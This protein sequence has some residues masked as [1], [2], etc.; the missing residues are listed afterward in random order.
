MQRGETRREFACEICYLTIDVY[1]MYGSHSIE[2]RNL[3]LR[4]A[5]RAPR[6]F[7][8]AIRVLYPGFVGRADDVG[9][10]L[11]PRNCGA[12]MPRRGPEGDTGGSSRNLR[13][14]P[15]LFVGAATSNRNSRSRKSARMCARVPF[16]HR[17]GRG[18]IPGIDLR[19]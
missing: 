15:A 9:A 4:R 1:Y 11:G 2:F 13:D 6:N 8:L 17:R 14:V 16:C 12:R 10:A 7:V 5:R 18:R 3:A 19:R